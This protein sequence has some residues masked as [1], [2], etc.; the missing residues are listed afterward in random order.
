MNN[1]RLAN[2]AGFLVCA[3]LLA[4]AFYSQF[5]LNVDPCPLCIFQ[6]VGVFA[7]GVVFLIAGLHN[8]KDWGR[9]V[10]A[11]LIGI[12]A[13]ATIGVAADH[14]YVQNLPEGAVPSCGAPLG[15]LFRFSPWLDVIKKVLTGSGECHV[16]NWQFLGLAMP[17]W[18][19]IWAVALGVWGVLANVRRAS[20]G[21]RLA[22]AT[23]H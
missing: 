2:L 13:L 18:V 21:P 20:G 14:L 15:M 23:K 17:A 1:R 16:V 19:L 7:L 3:G 5:A 12:A 11:V 8:P 4:Y 9:Y 10:Y 22:L 6:R